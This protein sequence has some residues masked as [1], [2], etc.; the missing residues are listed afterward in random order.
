[1]LASLEYPEANHRFGKPAG[2]TDEE[3]GTLPAFLG[4]REGR[5]VIITK[6]QP[7]LEDLN[8][9]NNGGA[10]YLEIVSGCLPPIDLYTENPFK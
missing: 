8:E 1:M 2:W 7:S 10:I 3:C 6:W 4:T 9:L 5:P